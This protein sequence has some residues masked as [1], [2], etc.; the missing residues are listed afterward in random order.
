MAY[1]GSNSRRSVQQFGPF[2]TGIL[3]ALAGLLAAS[4]SA[5]SPVAQP[6]STTTA[7]SIPAAQQAV[8][9]AWESAERAVYGYLDQ[10]VAPERAKL[11]AGEADAALWPSLATYFT[12]A[13]LQ[14]EDDLL[15]KTTMA[16]V[17]GPTGYNLGQ[18][19]V[20]TMTAS[21]A[22]LTSCISDSGTTTSSGQ[23]APTDL[24]GGAGSGRGTWDLQLAAGSWR[25]ATFR[26]TTVP[27]C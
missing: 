18:P 10:P 17:N 24:A 22:S 4:C 12:G 8:I 13:A 27:K 26:T 25:V 20:T 5:R 6:S 19:S 11:V 9:T 15:F 7:S 1:K 16:G 21:A 14:S 2:S 23:P 3:L